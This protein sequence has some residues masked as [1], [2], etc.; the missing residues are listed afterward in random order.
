MQCLIQLLFQASAND[1]ATLQI[2]PY[3]GAAL[4]EY[5]WKA[6]LVIYDDLTKQTM[7][8]RQMSLLFVHRQVSR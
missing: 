7:A 3:S 4:A 8:Y 5:L 2:A 1:P 6:T